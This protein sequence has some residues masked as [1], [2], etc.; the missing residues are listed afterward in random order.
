MVTSPVTFSPPMV[1]RVGCQDHLLAV[2]VAAAERPVDA[3]IVIFAAHFF[4]EEF[5]QFGGFLAEA[6]HEVE[7]V[8]AGQDA[9]P[10]GDVAA[11][12]ITAGFFAADQGVGLESSWGPHT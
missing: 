1:L 6:H 11:E 2:F 5:E 7:H 12:G 10:F 3:V 9:V 4:E 8:Q